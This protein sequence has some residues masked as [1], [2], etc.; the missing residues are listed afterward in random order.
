MEGA[1]EF[2]GGV[3][4]ACQFARTSTVNGNWASALQ[5]QRTLS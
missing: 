3:L 5:K 2:D 4:H 1:I